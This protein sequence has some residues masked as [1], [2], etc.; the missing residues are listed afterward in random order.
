MDAYKSGTKELLDVRDAESQMNQAELGLLNEKYT[1]LSA[2]LDLEYAV[3]TKLTQT[4]GG[5]K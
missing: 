2:L 1:Y 4:N 5:Q 3:N